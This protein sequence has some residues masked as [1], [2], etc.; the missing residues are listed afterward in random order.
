MRVI[1]LLCLCV[2]CGGG[3]SVSNQSSETEAS[4][5]VRV[6]DVGRFPRTATIPLEAGRLHLGA[7]SDGSEEVAVV[8]EGEGGEL[9]LFA[10]DRLEAET[11]ESGFPLGRVG[12]EQEGEVER[13]GG[14]IP[15]ARLRR[16]AEEQAP[17]L[18]TCDE[19]I[20]L[21]DRQVRLLRAFLRGEAPP[22]REVFDSRSIALEGLDLGFA[23]SNRRPDEVRVEIRILEPVMPLEECDMVAI[24]GEETFPLGM[25]SLEPGGPSPRDHDHLE[26]RI[27]RRN[28]QLLAQEDEASFIICGDVWLLDALTL[29][30]IRS[31]VGEAPPTEE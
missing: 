2:A 23:I 22:E 12:Y 17:R 29:Q 8:L 9:V 30:N 27:P 4:R 7:A 31:L 10:C 20:E 13:I 16:L 19:E 24:V 18:H 5:A 11:G 28:V 21:D 6:P 3:Q 14:M 1:G 26:A 25:T 15:R